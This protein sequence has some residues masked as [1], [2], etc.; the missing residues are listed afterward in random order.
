MEARLEMLDVST[1][2]YDESFN[3]RG[4][5]LPVTC[6]ELAN[7][8]KA[9]GMHEPVVVA[10]KEEGGYK[11]IM[12][13]RRFIAVTKCLRLKTIKAIIDES[14][15][16]LRKAKLANLSENIQREDLSLIQEITAIRSMI[17]MHIPKEEIAGRCGKSL[18]WVGQR[19]K[20]SE[21]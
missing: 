2:E 9:E 4:K 5:I 15:T 18:G 19:L 3:C 11:L 14:M 12:G 20:I 7:N 8:I 6:N 21:F 17:R 10:P 16:D 1:I 13:H